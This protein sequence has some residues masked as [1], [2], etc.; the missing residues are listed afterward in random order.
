MVRFVNAKIN[1]GLNIIRKRADGYHELETLFY[2]VG[3]YNGTPE[4]PQP[5]NDILEVDLLA[6]CGEVDFHFLGNP[7]DCPMEKNLVVRAARLFHSLF[8]QRYGATRQIIV[9]LEKHIPDGAGL[10]GGSADASFTLMMLNELH[11]NP[12]AK[13]ELIEM[14]ASLGADCPFFIEN[15]PVLATGI[16]E[17]MKPIEADLAG[18]WA[19]IAKPNIYVS[20]REAFSGITPRI[21]DKTISEIIRLPIEEWEAAGLKNDFERH[22][23]ALHPRLKEIKDELKARGALYAAMSGSGSSLFGIFSGKEEAET[24]Y[25]NLKDKLDAADKIFI[26]KL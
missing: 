11:G 18:K 12:F 8:T 13:E 9:T 2:P 24:A 17:I 22:I 21:P 7:I 23:F 15:R 3:L 14:A 20:T 19:V 25:N 1:L 4:N 10:G 16:G 6:D 26:C 5:F